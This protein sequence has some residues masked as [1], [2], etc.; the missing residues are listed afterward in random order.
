MNRRL[1]PF[2]YTLLEDYTSN[3]FPYIHQYP[4]QNIVLE[5]ED[6]MC[7]VETTD[8]RATVYYKQ[9]L[10]QISEWTKKW[11]EDHKLSDYAIQ[12]IKV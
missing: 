8:K 12:A 3:I 7:L 2:E 11:L 5:S 4:I 1:Q 6:G 9:E 10:E